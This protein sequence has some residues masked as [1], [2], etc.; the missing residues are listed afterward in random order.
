MI[1]A[2]PLE[3]EYELNGAFQYR[4]ENVGPLGKRRRVAKERSPA[5]ARGLDDRRAVAD[6][7]DILRGTWSTPLDPSQY[8]P[9]NRPYGSKASINVRKPHKHLAEVSKRTM[10]R[11]EIH[12]DVA[13]SWETLGL[14]GE[15]PDIHTFERDTW[16]STFDLDGHVVA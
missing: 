10:L 2:G 4:R 11:R 9:E 5:I 3:T 15:P 16:E 14:P 7:I 1:T 12:D 6:D 13:A 8:P